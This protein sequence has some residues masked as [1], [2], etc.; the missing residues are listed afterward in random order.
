MPTKTREKKAGEGKTNALQKPLQPSEELAAVVER[1]FEMASLKLENDRLRDQLEAA[2]SAA[3]FVAESP[4]S[5]QL[6]E[7]VRRVIEYVN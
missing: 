1:A 3:G 4:Q 2:I 5:K 7:M 6:A